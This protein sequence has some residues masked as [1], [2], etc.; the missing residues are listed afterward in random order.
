VGSDLNPVPVLITRTLTEV[1]PAVHDQ[2]PLH[3]DSSEDSG[4]LLCRSRSY[5]GYEG[6]KTDVL[7]YA[8]HVNERARALLAAHYPERPGERAIAWLWARTAKCTNPECG[9]ETVLT[10][11]WWLSKRRGAMAWIQPRVSDGRVELNV[12]TEANTGGPKD[13][14]KVERPRATAFR[15][16]CWPGPAAVAALAR[17]TIELAPR[18]MTSGPLTEFVYD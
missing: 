5:A 8:E 14:P 6:L 15:P 1:L 11:S 7:H 16:G 2:Q 12:V 18:P 4:L 9:V 13:P 10:T 17:L 3:P